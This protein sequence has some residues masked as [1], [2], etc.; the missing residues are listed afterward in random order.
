MNSR[1]LADIQPL[2]R[3]EKEKRYS[4]EYRRK[5]L[6]AIEALASRIAKV[7]QQVAELTQLSR[8]WL[9]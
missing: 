2:D 9:Q 3:R 7:E 1:S 4:R 6:A 8:K 5:K